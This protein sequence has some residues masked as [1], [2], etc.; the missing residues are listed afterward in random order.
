MSKTQKII[1][2]AVTLS[3]EVVNLRKRWKNDTTETHK[4][5]FLKFRRNFEKNVRG[6]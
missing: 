1:F 6:I 5:P 2:A 4:L 3:M